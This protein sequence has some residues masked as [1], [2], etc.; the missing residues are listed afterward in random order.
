METVYDKNGYR[1]L[2]FTERQWRE[3]P[4]FVSSVGATLDKIRKDNHLNMLF[5]LSADR[6]TFGISDES[7]CGTAGCLAGHAFLTLAPGARHVSTVKDYQDVRDA[8]PEPHD[9]FKEG[10]RLLGIREDEAKQLF[11]VDRWPDLIRAQYEAAE[12]EPEALQ[13]RERYNALVAAVEWMIGKREQRRAKALRYNTGRAH[14]RID[15]GP[16]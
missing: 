15:P 3:D 14:Q 7:P 12:D 4:E 10:S 13:Q 5:W 1:V 11:I 9:W 6:Y 8:A 2:Q 16:E